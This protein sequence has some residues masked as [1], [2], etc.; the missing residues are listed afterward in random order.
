MIAALLAD[1]RRLARVALV[2][3]AVGMFILFASMRR[4]RYNRAT[5]NWL[6]PQQPPDGIATDLGTLTEKQSWA[7]NRAAPMNACC[8]DRGAGR[9]VR[10]TYPGTLADHPD[11]LVA[12]SV[13][14]NLSAGC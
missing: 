2:V 5:P 8:T 7:A 4:D 9:R 13:R 6:D 10:R 12:G 1:R 11:S 14:I 3:V